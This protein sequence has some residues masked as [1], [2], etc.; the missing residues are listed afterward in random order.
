MNSNHG[1]VGAA[2]PRGANVG[3]G[4]VGRRVGG[5][6]LPVA[7]GALEDVGDVATGLAVIQG[8]EAAGADWHAASRTASVAAGTRCRML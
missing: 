4:V 2:G 5:T 7:A 3:G 8:V 6:E 1:S